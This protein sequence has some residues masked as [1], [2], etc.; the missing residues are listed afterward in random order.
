MTLGSL[1]VALVASAY[2]LF[3]S[4]SEGR[5]LASEIGDP[6]LSRYGAGMFYSV[7]NV[8]FNEPAGRSGDGLLVNRL[9]ETFRR[10]ADEG[11]HLGATVRYSMGPVA[12][13]TR[14]GGASGESGPVLGRLVAASGAEDQVEILEGEPGDGGVLLPDLI[15]DV[16]SVGPG[17]RVE[18]GGEV[19]LT[20]AAV[21]RSLYTQP[22]LGYWVP[23]S[24]DLFRPCPDCS[25]PPQYVLVDHEEFRR[26]SRD[27]GA[28][29]AD[30]GWVAPIDARLS[31]DEARE[32]S[33]YTDRIKDEMTRRRSELGSLF[34]C[35][36]RNYT[37]FPFFGRRDTE[38]RSA[39]PLVLREVD[40]RAATVEGP[41][42]LL[43][44]AGLGVAGAVV[45]A[46]AAFAV[47][48]R[49]TEAAL[50]HARGWGP[51]RFA[52]RAAVEA[53]LPVAA[54]AVAGLG[55]GSALVA[56]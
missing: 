35:C 33:V 56:V 5:L 34:A 14:P 47:A 25:A 20:V 7:T 42:R 11:P 24:E 32:V 17:D 36:G 9:D 26:L 54:G 4:R 29:D 38:F 45:A 48:G 46:A 13:A 18:L 8:R 50:L 21:Y 30:Y 23:W 28:R 51:A 31:V 12:E 19:E 1:L 55:A 37:G 43:L 44:I 15:A 3:L 49:R 41:L 2:P 53:F 10:L 16:L 52:V 22:R 6:T 39:M 40:R 27:L